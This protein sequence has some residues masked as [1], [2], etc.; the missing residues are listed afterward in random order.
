M[1]HASLNK[2]KREEATAEVPIRKLRR[3][4]SARFGSQSDSLWNDV[5]TTESVRRPN[6]D[7]AWDEV[8]SASKPFGMG[9]PKPKPNSLSYQTD[10]SSE[11]ASD[12]PA[13]L[14]LQNTNLEGLFCNKTF[15]IHGFTERQ[16]RHCEPSKMGVILALTL[17]R[18]VSSKDTCGHTEDTFR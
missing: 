5:N 16:V 4:A 2:R 15:S 13:L 8:L 3:T 10:Q 18:L 6:T 17:V 9:V 12:T 1:S 11:H 7:S 14:S